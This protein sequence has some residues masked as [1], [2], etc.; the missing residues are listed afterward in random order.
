MPIAIVLVAATAAVAQK[1]EE[2]P[3]E[4]AESVEPAEAPAVPAAADL[5]SEAADR[6]TEAR[7]ATEL[8]FDEPSGA[9]VV[10]EADVEGELE[11]DPAVL[12]LT[13]RKAE[14]EG[15][16]AHHATLTSNP[17]KSHVVRQ[18][19]EV[20]Q[21]LE[22]TIEDHKA[23]LRPRVVEQLASGNTKDKAAKDS[24]K[25]TAPQGPRKIAPGDVLTIDVMDNF[26]SLEQLGLHG[27][28]LLL[29]PGMTAPIDADGRL[30]LGS[31]YPN[32][33]VSGQ[34]LGE[35]AARI[36]DA[37]SNTTKIHY[38]PPR[39][40]E[41]ETEKK[42]IG[43]LL[44]QIQINVLLSF[45]PREGEIP[46]RAQA[47][48][49]IS[50]YKKPAASLHPLVPSAPVVTSET[51]PTPKN[52]YASALRAGGESDD[53]HGRIQRG[54]V[55]NIEVDPPEAMAKPVSVVEPDGR[56]ALGVRFGRV[57]VAGKTLTEAE[58]II[59]KA[60]APIFRNP[61][62]QVTYARLAGDEAGNSDRE[63]SALARVRELER[64]VA[65]LK[66]TIQSLKRNQPSDTVPRARRTRPTAPTPRPVVPKTPPLEDAPPIEPP[67]LDTSPTQPPAADTPSPLSD[68]LPSDAADQKDAPPNG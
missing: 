38:R 15:M 6:V 27:L 55:L 32:I 11:K 41:S 65:E 36:E 66:A 13:K 43:D 18:L 44:K 34:S 45:A 29:R 23:T 9:S 53:Q 67:A 26:D 19:R 60:I 51:F 57:N 59:Q 5:A 37:L 33:V 4:P 10:K 63:T 14:Y 68:D 28:R 48:T 8:P 12:Q 25:S 40:S 31:R 7:A 39:G 54:D 62:V 21:Q 22:Q 61:S 35:A 1:Q 30:W 20:I 64:E 3:A 46:E 49:A 16:L 24:E 2:K 56:L 17:N 42:A 47:P 52:P 58:A 50:G